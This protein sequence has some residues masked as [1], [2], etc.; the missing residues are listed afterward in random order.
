[1]DFRGLTEQNPSHISHGQIEHLVSG[2]Q[3]GPCY[4]IVKVILRIWKEGL[5]ITGRWSCSVVHDGLDAL[6]HVP[7][8]TSSWKWLW[9]FWACTHFAALM[10]LDRLALAVL[11][12]AL[13]PEL[14]ASHS[15]Y[16]NCASQQMS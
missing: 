11:R 4:Q 10:A 8:V 1:M 12:V 13:S 14:Q 7:C 15:R 3:G 16:Y 6:P 5:T 2:E 9:D